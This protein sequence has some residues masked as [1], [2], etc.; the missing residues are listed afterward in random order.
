MSF[1]EFLFE[2]NN[3]IY[4]EL[5]QLYK[6]GDKNSEK[7]AEK[8][9]A[10][11]AKKSGYTIGPVWHGDP[12]EQHNIYHP[13]KT[14]EGGI[15]FTTSHAVAKYFSGPRNEPRSFYLNITNIK[16]IEP[17]EV[18]EPEDQGWVHSEKK[19]RE[20]ILKAKKQ[21]FN[22]V[23]IKDIDEEAGISD[24]YIAFYSEQI[25]LSNPFT[26]D[27]NIILLDKRFDKTN[28]DIRY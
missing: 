7:K 23:I 10:E 4:L 17:D 24:Q 13:E 11:A 22:G 1:K 14:T 6:N 28:P 19:M 18:M 16:E 21:K 2:N 3:S 5:E 15:F 26:Y 12:L 8:L 9:V 27:N 20:A 25:K